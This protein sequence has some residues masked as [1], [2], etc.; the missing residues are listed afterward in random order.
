MIVKLQHH[1]ENVALQIF[2]VF[3]ESYK[4]EAAII[5]VDDFPPLSRHLDEIKHSKAL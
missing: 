1:D 4:I 5:G 3:Q 2:S